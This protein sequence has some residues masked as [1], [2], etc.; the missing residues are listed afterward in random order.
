MMKFPAINPF[1]AL[2]KVA[3]VSAEI[4]VANTVF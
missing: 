1:V 3:V 4:V 2:C